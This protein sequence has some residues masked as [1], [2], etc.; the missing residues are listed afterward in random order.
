VEKNIFIL[1]IFTTEAIS[2]VLPAPFEEKSGYISVDWGSVIVID[3]S[4]TLSIHLEI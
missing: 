2:I 1:Q 4:K 3:P